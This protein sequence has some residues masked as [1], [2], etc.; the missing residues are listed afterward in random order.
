MKHPTSLLAEHTTVL[1][2]LVATLPWALP[3][4]SFDELLAGANDAT[5]LELASLIGQVVK[6]SD[7]VAVRVAGEVAKRSDRDLEM[8]LSKRMGEKSGAALVC[9][10][11]GAIGRRGEDWCYVGAQLTTRTNLVGEVLPCLRPVVAAAVDAGVLGLDASRA[12]LDALTTVEPV[13]TA[14]KL[15][16]LE[17]H[18]VNQAQLLPL[19]ELL[20][21]CRRVPDTLDPDGAEPREEQ[22]R[23]LAGMT[24]IARIQRNGLYRAVIQAD[25]ESWAFL[26][27]ALDARLTPKRAMRFVDAD[28]LDNPNPLKT[29]TRTLPQ[30]RL[31][32]LVSIAKDSLKADDGD[33]S[34][35]AVTVLVT[36]S[37][38]ALSTGVG[39]ATIFGVDEPISATTARRLAC[40]A[41]IIPVVLSGDSQPLDLGTG[42][43]LFSLAQRNAMA[44]RDGGCIWP[45][46]H[47]PPSRC[48]SA[49]LTPWD[50]GGPTDLANGVLLCPFHHRRFDLDGWS[51]ITHRSGE[52]DLIPPPWV[53]AARTP[54][55]ITRPDIAV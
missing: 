17:V 35:T 47:E 13:L 46:C 34:G 11:T 53:D 18:L 37:H 48:Q 44:V 43:R 8:P 6:L 26:N 12:I 42:R 33:M 21:L 5:L 9:S 31:D 30:R 45:G 14:E 22:I 50:K 41:N 49:H 51:L 10:L 38:E 7:A 32:A 52:R 1:A 23:E 19:S 40:E 39:S 20:K 2:E 16:G 28:E 4:A 15:A 3:G 54:R 55:R 36:V 24:V 29:D 25:P 27:T